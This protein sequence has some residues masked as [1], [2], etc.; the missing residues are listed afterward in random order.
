MNKVIIGLIILTIVI[1]LI[2]FSMVTLKEC[3]ETLER[4]QWVERYER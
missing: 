4:T 3:D 2:M 1:G